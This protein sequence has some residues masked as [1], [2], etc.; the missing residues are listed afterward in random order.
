[1]GQPLGSLEEEQ[2]HLNY[3]K[4]NEP[5]VFTRRMVFL[6]RLVSLGE[7]KVHRGVQ[8]LQHKHK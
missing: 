7:G 8:T 3:A 1:M 4:A 6:E 2:Q 5:P